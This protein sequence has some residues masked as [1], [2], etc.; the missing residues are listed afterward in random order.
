MKNK[1]GFAPVLILVIALGVL[2]VGGVA[3]F[4][5]KSSAPKN[6]VSDN[7]NY[8][9]PVDQN[10]NPPVT[11]NTNVTPPVTANPSV[12]IISPNGGETFTQGGIISGSYTTANIP[13]GTSCNWYITGNI[14]G[15]PVGAEMGGGK[16]ISTGKQI[17]SGKISTS[18]IPGN[19]KVEVDCENIGSSHLA[20][21]DQ[22]DSNFTITAQTNTSNLKTYT[23]TKYGF[24]FKYPVNDGK[25][26]IYKVG[27]F[28]NTNEAQFTPAGL[29]SAHDT[30]SVYV[31]ES[32]DYKPT[33]NVDVRGII[34]PPDL[35][36]YAKDKYSYSQGQ[37]QFS[38]S[39]YVNINGIQWLKAK[40]L[41]NFELNIGP[42]ARYEYITTRNN[43]FYTMS[44]NGLNY[45]IDNFKK[46]G[47]E[48]II[49]TL[50]FTK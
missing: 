31:P 18:T 22:S 37:I 29:S 21:K 48:G 13:N 7:S 32:G 14:N 33:F 50:K 43:N 17:F 1:K 19:Y 20:V 12:T 26:G 39:E 46:L 3:Y 10:Y 25:G 8:F 4:A 2:A 34:S 41:E 42:T 47:L 45:T 36:T 27:E 28:S 44:L 30:V 5:G 9:P 38:S 35:F 16:I 40:Y 23:N 11:S 24:E 6:D 49:F 15:I